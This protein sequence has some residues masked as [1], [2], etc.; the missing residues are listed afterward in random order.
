MLP[1][2][3]PG[4][5]VRRHD[6]MVIYLSKF[7]VVIGSLFWHQCDLFQ[8]DRVTLLIILLLPYLCKKDILASPDLINFQ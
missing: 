8:I 3:C 7:R 2:E 5:G 6:E 1:F 4:C